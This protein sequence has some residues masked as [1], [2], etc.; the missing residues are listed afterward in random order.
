MAGSNKYEWRYIDRIIFK[1]F[2]KYKQTVEIFGYKG[3][4]HENIPKL[5][6]LFHKG[7]DFYYQTK[8]EKAIK[9]FTSC[10]KYETINH[11]NTINPSIVF[12]DKCKEYMIK[13]PDANWDGITNLKEK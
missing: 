6:D 13:S 9:I 8:W 7:L 5:I 4:V 1:G 11:S 10:L 3:E 2:T 12:I